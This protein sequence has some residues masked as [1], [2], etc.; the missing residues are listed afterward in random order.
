MF[1]GVKTSK[2]IVVIRDKMKGL[3]FIELSPNGKIKMLMTWVFLHSG[4]I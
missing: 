4:N 3:K 2:I 1:D